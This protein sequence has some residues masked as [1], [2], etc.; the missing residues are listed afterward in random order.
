[1]AFEMSCVFK[2]TGHKNCASINANFPGLLSYT[3]LG[4]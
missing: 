3:L 4:L 1:M 2:K